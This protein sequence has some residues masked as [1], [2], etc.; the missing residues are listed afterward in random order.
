MAGSVPRGREVAMPSVDPSGR[1]EPQ[2]APDDERP[3]ASV[4]VD[5]DEDEPAYDEVEIVDED[6]FGE[7]VNESGVDDDEDDWDRTEI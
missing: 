7:P 6:E 5:P 2:P 1:R 4:P 3:P